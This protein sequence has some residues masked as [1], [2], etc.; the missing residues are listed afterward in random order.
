MRSQC[1]RETIILMNKA[2]YVCAGA[3]EISLGIYVNYRFIHF[4]S[5]RRIEGK[6]VTRV[7]KEVRKGI[8]KMKPKKIK[9]KQYM[10]N[11][12]MDL[13]LFKR[14]NSL[15]LR[16]GRTWPQVMQELLTLWCDEEA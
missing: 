11:V 5:H 15:R 4:P 14:A 3:D 7:I 9:L 8:R 16:K 13:A 10:F 1:S 12:R 2:G 6:E